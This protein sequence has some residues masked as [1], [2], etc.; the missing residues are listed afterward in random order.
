M[1]RNLISKQA[2]VVAGII[3]AV[4]ILLSPAF[5]KEACL[6]LSD[7]KND[8]DGKQVPEK[9]A[10]VIK[11]PS[12]AVTSTQSCEI[13]DANPTVIREIILEEGQQP[14]HVTL[15][16]AIFSSLFKTLFRT[17]ISPQAP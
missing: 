17:I 15:S 1:K 3:A 13:E 16:K 12:D 11:A 9:E 7:I 4:I 6:F 14:K 10:T 5:Q 2:M 8:K